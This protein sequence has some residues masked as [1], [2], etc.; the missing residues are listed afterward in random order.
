MAY[1]RYYHD[2]V[3]S[4]INGDSQTRGIVADCL[5][6]MRQIRC[7]AEA[8]ELRARMYWIGY[9]VKSEPPVYRTIID[10]GELLAIDQ[11]GNIIC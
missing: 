10:D 6:G 1:S 8:R 3:A 2:G 5:R 7:R 11:Y 4:L 9:P